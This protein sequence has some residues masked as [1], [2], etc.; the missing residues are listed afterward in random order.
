MFGYVTVFKPELKI[1]DYVKYRAYYCGLCRVLQQNYGFTGQMTLSYDMTFCVILLTSLYECETKR[2]NRRCKVH[3][4]K[5][6]PILFNEMTA[7]AAD[8]NIV[9]SYYHFMDDWHD[10]HSLSGFA[11]MAALKR[12]VKKIARKYPR[13]CRQIRQ[14]LKALAILEKEDCQ[15]IDE[16]A[17]RFGDLMAELLVYKK[18]MWEP[19]LRRIGFYLGKYIY[20]MDAVDDI[21]KD[22]KSVS[23]NPL[24][25][26][27]EQMTKEAFMD[28]CFQMLT[29]MISEVSASFECLPCLQDIDILRNVLYAG[30]WNKFNKIEE[31]LKNG[32]KK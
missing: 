9:L 24:K 6:S 23:F 28:T 31:D 10:D 2:E 1:K 30:V 7:Y 26:M 15:N 22:I 8:M 4:L 5:K 25:N 29:L 13:Q 19:Y 14:C 16:T 27:H 32:S 3:P 11:G 18:D 20:I 12:K 17:G 21:E